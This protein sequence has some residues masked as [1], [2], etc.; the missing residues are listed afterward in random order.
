MFIPFYVLW[1]GA[2][3]PMTRVGAGGW[4]LE[5]TPPHLNYILVFVGF[6]FAPMLFRSQT[7]D[8]V[9][10]G[11]YVWLVTLGLLAVYL[12]FPLQL[13]DI[14]GHSVVAG[15]VVHGVD[16]VGR[17]TWS[18]VG[19]VA[20]LVLWG[21]GLLIVLAE[22]SDGLWTEEKTWLVGVALSYIGLMLVTPFVYERYY[23]VLVPILILV[24]HRTFHS[25][26][27]LSWWVGVQVVM[28]GGFTFWQAVL[29]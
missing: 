9:K 15:I 14:A 22:W 6:Y 10:T 17:L 7:A 20:K 13:N 23:E 19:E 27:V 25:R 4:H 12:I 3:P 5:L 26:R 24:I 2:T 21:M 8:L 1:G 29:K 16:L 28:A 11:R 18:G